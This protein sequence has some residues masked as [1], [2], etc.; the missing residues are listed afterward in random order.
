LLHG[1]WWVVSGWSTRE[2]GQTQV[3]HAP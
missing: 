3:S 2:G 1:L